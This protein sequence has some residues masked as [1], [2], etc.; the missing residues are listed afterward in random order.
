MQH[1]LNCIASLHTPI[2]PVSHGHRAQYYRTVVFA[3]PCVGGIQQHAAYKRTQRYGACAKIGIARGL[4][5]RRP[6]DTAPRTEP[7]CF[8]KIPPTGPLF[9]SLSLSPLPRLRVTRAAASLDYL[10]VAARSARHP[11][12][13]NVLRSFFSFFRFCFVKM[14]LLL[15]TAAPIVPFKIMRVL[16]EDKGPFTLGSCFLIE[17]TVAKDRL[18]CDPKGRNSLFT[19]VFQVPVW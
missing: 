5:V 17:R 15:P 4:R 19:D 1:K 2:S 7:C 14:S 11:A 3:W 18:A 12:P 8:P 6:R 9:R 13:D 16:C 10:R